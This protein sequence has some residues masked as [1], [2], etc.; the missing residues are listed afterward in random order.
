MAARA[1]RFQASDE[2]CDPENSQGVTSTFAVVSGSGIKRCQI[3]TG[4]A[5]FVSDYCESPAAHPSNGFHQSA[6]TK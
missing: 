4:S 1:R 5:R 3:Q 2:R 6:Q